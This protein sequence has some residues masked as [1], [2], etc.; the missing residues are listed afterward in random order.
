LIQKTVNLVGNYR[1]RRF[2]EASSHRKEAVEELQ[3][4][5]GDAHSDA[6]RYYE[7]LTNTSLDPLKQA[8]GS[9][10]KIEYPSGLH[11]DN[12]KGY[13][14]E[15]VAAHLILHKEPFE[16]GDWEVPVFR[17]RFHHV[18]FEQLSLAAQ[19]GEDAPNIPGLTGEDVLAI[20]TNESGE[21]I[22][23][24]VCESKCTKDHS[25]TVIAKAHSQINAVVVPTII[26]QVIAI[27][28]C[29]DPEKTKGL[30]AALQLLMLKYDENRSKRHN[31]ISYICGQRPKQKE[32]WID[33]KSPHEKYSSP[34]KLEVAE[35]HLEDVDDLVSQAYKKKIVK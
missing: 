17:F 5:V 10:P 1:H 8:D 15:I 25:A 24:L 6:I 33:P 18:A 14:G 16:T 31:L 23:F 32:T 2:D 7:S 30:V 12:L 11:L 34:Q 35:L 20:R 13:F 21:I 26:P 9:Y 4:L 28:K 19:T 3:K 22:A 29:K 27:L